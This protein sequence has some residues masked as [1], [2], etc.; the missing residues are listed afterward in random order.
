[1][2]S[3]ACQSCHP[4][5]FD[6]WHHSFHRSMTQ[7]ASTESVLANFDDVKLR[8]KKE[9]FRLERRGDEFW[10]EMTDPDWQRELLDRR[11]DPAGRDD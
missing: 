9:P 8:L 4:E 10:A 1:M 6:S 11:I 2:T 7:R 3:D 5:A